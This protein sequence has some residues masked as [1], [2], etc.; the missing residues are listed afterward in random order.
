MSAESE[1]TIIYADLERMMQASEITGLAVGVI[2]NG[3]VDRL[4]TFGTV[5]GLPIQPDTPWLVA[6]LTKPLFVYAVLQLVRNG[7]LDL[8]RPLQEY[9]DAPY[10]AGVPLLD[11][12]TAR[13]A[14]MHTGGLPNWRSGDGLRV[15]SEPGTRFSYSSE[16]LTYLQH[17]VENLIGTSMHDHL[18]THIFAPLGMKHSEL[19]FETPTDLPPTLH[20]LS[21]SLLANGALSLRTTLADYTR[22]MLTVWSDH[23]AAVTELRIAVGAIPGLYW[24]LGW[25]LQALQSGLSCWHW[26]ARSSPRTMSFALALP[27]QRRAI[28]VFTNHANGLSLC[29]DIIAHWSGEPSLPAF[30]WLLPAHLWRADG[31]ASAVE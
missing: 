23:A 10:V 13:H 29:H 26:G 16:G 2:E 25:G 4:D 30:D 20:F 5:D 19:R 28:V 17:V 15:Q 24:G 8:D 11:R 31:K 14:M 3:T 27:A 7:L 9:L 22:F 18:R 12:I 6:S 1:Q 21:G